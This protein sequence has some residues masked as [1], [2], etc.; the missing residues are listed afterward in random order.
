MFLLESP[1]P[2]LL[3]GIALEAALGLTLLRTGQGKWLW[4]M[5]GVGVV[6]VG[7]LLAE[8]FAVTDRKL[9]TQTLDTAAAAVRDNNMPGLLDCISPDADKLRARLE[10]AL[11]PL[12]VPMGPHLPPRHPDQPLHQ[13]THG[14]GPFPG[15][16]RGRGPARGD[17]SRRLFPRRGCRAEMENDRWLV[18]DYSVEG[19][20][21]VPL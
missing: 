1:W 8:H 18:G 5:L 3:I 15:I 6:V 12:Q 16:R 17:S 9:I 14:Q 2:I 21:Q 10:T 11:G 4:A 7:G 13:P 19:L 20:P